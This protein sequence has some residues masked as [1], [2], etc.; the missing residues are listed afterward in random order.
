MQAILKWAGGKDKELKYILPALPENYEDYY[1]PFVGGG[2]VFMAVEA[3]R[4][5]INDLSTELIALY[6]CI[7]AG[8]ALF[9]EYAEAIDNAW[10]AADTFFAEHRDLAELYGQYSSGL[11][12]CDALARRI[13]DFCAATAPRIEAMAAALP[14]FNA[15][16]IVGEMQRNLLRK[17]LR[18]CKLEHEKHPLPA[19]DI[20]DNLLTAIKSALYMYFRGLYNDG[21]IAADN[22][23]LHCALFL[24]IRNYCYSGMFRY[25]D[26]G[27]FN[28][29]YGGMAYNS[30]RLAHKLDYYRCNDLV[31][32]LA[33]TTSECADFE[34]FFRR[35]KPGENDFVFLDP[36][37]DSEFSTYAQNEFSRLDHIRLANYLLNVC[38][39][40]WMLV[41]KNTDF[42]HTLYNHPGINIK[43]FDKTYQVSLMNRNDRAAQHLL[44]TNYSSACEIIARNSGQYGH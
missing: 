36:P 15:G 43:A 17:M 39:A 22:P 1:E 33:E 38:P 23:A 41:I 32:R 9:F 24:F 14:E 28:V 42:I 34:E 20:D 40:R 7:A 30:K 35:N 37:Y 26:D 4:Y 19:S 21:R 12:D 3:R 13:D 29:P 25:N 8:D 5:F 31:E 27:E 44:I 16:L 6:R 10:G 2:S 18:M 11:I